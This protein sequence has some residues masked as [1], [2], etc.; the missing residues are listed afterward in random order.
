MAA[1]RTESD[2]F[3]DVRYER[4]AK[5]AGLADADHARGKMARLWR[6]C[7][8]EKRYVLPVDDVIQVLGENAV[9]ALTESRLGESVDGGIRIRGTK[10]RIEWLDK[11][12]K[13]GQKGG[14]PKKTKSKPSGFQESNP[15][16]LL[17][18]GSATDQIRERE[19]TPPPLAP[20]PPDPKPPKPDVAARLWAEQERLR[21]LAMPKSRGL[22][23][24]DDR[25]KRVQA[26]L[27]EGYSEADLMAC[28]AEYAREARSNGG[29]WFNGD[30]NW[31]PDN[32]ARTLGRIG[33]GGPAQAIDRKRALT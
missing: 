14:R 31:R 1:V 8:M 25:R 6:Q 9:G 7:T 30:T 16:A 3:G 26:R 5:L 11:L 20:I 17:C 33:S 18:S 12:R 24:T 27:D 32:V 10:G 21:R 2:A 13:N 29:E 15:L 22:E 19:A 28:L 23:L 4:L